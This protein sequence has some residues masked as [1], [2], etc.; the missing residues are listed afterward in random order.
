MV[1][2]FADHEDIA[3]L[4]VSFQTRQKLYD[5]IVTLHRLANCP[6]RSFSFG[7]WL[8]WF[9]HALLLLDPGFDSRE[10]SSSLILIIRPVLTASFILLAR[11]LLIVAVKKAGVVD[12][13]ALFSAENKIC[14]CM[15]VV[16]SNLREGYRDGELT[17][18]PTQVFSVNNWALKPNQPEEP[19]FTD[20]M[21]AICTA[22]MPVHSTSS[23][24]SFMFSKE[25]TKGGSSKAPTDSKTGHSKKRKESSSD[26]DSNPSQPLISILVDIEMHK[27][28]QQATGGPNSLGVTSEERANPQLSSGMSTFNLNKPIYST[29]FIIH[30][31]SASGNDASAVST[32]EADPGNSAPSDFVPQQQGMNEGTKNTSYDHLFTCTDPH[33]LADQTKYVSEGLKTVLTQPIIGKGASSVARQIE[34]E[35]SSSIKLEDLAKLVS[36]VQPSFKDLDSPKDD[37]VIVVDDTDEDEEDEIHA[38]TNDETKDTSV[39]KS[40][41]QSY[42]NLRA[43]QP[44]QPS[45]PNVEQLNELLVKSLK[46]EF[47][48]IL[49]VHDFSSSLP[50]ELK[51]LP[52]KFN[53]LTEEVKGLKKQ[54]H[55]L[56]IE[57]LGDLKEIPTK[58]RLYKDLQVASVQAKLKTLDALPSLLLNVTQ[59]LNK[60]AK[61]E[62]IKEGK[63]KKAL[64][65]KEAEK[66]CT[67]SD[68]D[69][70]THVT[71]SMVKP[72]R[73]KKLNK[74]DFITED[75]RHFHLTEEEIN[76][77]KKLEED[78]KAEA[79]KQEGE[80]RK[81]ELVDMFGP[82]VVK[83][84]YN[85][86]LQYDKYCDKVLNRR[87]V[88]RITNRDVLTR[89]GPITLKVYREDGR[90]EII[91]NFKAS[92]LHLGEWR[93]V[94]K[95]CPNRTGKG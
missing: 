5:E 66:E 57:L 25:A 82:E 23:K 77:Q 87:A 6:W 2:A 34:E 22:D 16:R 21:L 92:D 80:V 27:E 7:A 14:S 13:V 50:T 54:V 51:D 40:L 85:D 68:S 88:S 65:L 73:T 43:Y 37:P 41:S 84:Y 71:R 31:E 11:Y 30:S 94:M 62:H 46:T 8:T 64:S 86:K 79:A 35:T 33:V 55:E 95:A 60:F 15:D 53:K 29:S 90:S 32:A 28:D 49:S 20:H 69:D 81:A 91:P 63:G 39:P 1:V 26:M 19:P 74:F 56:E 75:G 42:Q 67:D 38:A 17:I 70:E 48:N 52:S 89:K 78:A 44:A 58:L 45:F 3:D 93:E 18:H 61:G 83:K 47:S 9:F 4:W 72:L 12:N 10:G 76:H 24:Q 36:H 59:A